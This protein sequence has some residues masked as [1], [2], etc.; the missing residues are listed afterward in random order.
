MSATPL[1]PG[2]TTPPNAPERDLV[3]RRDALTIC[4]PPL[5]DDE[6]SDDGA[7]EPC[8]NCEG[9]GYT[10]CFCGGGLC[11]CENNGEEPC[12]SCV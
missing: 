10:D 12:W 4:T 7:E 2:F 9:R 3:Y 5:R 8:A 11:V 6:L 1:F